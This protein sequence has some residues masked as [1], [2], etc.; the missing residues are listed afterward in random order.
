MQQHWFYD[1]WP[2]IGG[3]GGNRDGRHPADDRHIP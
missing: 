2:F 3:G 1:V